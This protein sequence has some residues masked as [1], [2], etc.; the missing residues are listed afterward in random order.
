MKVD[1]HPY[2][3]HA[4]RFFL[5]FS[6]CLFVVGAAKGF[7]QDAD[8]FVSRLLQNETDESILAVEVQGDFI[9]NDVLNVYTNGQFIKSKVIEGSDIGDGK[10]VVVKNISVDV[11]R[12]G[13]NDI[14]VAI[15]RQG[16]EE[17]QTEPFRITIQTVPDRPILAVTKVEEDGG[18]AAEVTTP[19][20]VDDVVAV[21]LNGEEVVTVPVTDSLV[22]KGMVSV[23]LQEALF[24]EGDNRIEALIRRGDLEGGLSSRETV[25]IAS[26]EEGVAVQSTIP[27]C[28]AYTEQQYIQPEYRGK[29]DEFGTSVALFGSTVAIGNK[30]G[31]VEVFAKSM[32][33][34]EEVWKHVT[35]FEG[36]RY[37]FRHDN[38]KS[39]LLD[40][41]ERLLVGT[42]TADYQGGQSG[43]VEVFARSDDKWSGTGIIAP[44]SLG[45]RELFGTHIA[46][47]DT[48]MVV[49]ALRPD[50][51]GGIYVYE[52]DSRDS[53][54]GPPTIITPRSVTDAMRF[55]EQVAVGEGTIAV[56]SPGSFAIY[57]YSKDGG[58]WVEE[59]VTARH[60]STD[61]LFGSRL[62]LVN[63]MLIVGAPGEGEQGMV[64]IYERDRRD[65]WN[66]TQMLPAPKGARDFGAEMAYVDGALAVGAP[67]TNRTGAVFVFTHRG[68]VWRLQDTVMPDMLSL[69]DR[70]GSS[71]GMYGTTLVVGAPGD[72]A[73]DSSNVGTAYLFTASESVC[74]AAVVGGVVPEQETV[75]PEENVQNL[76]ERQEELEVLNEDV[77]AL[78]GAISQNIVAAM[79]EVVRHEDRIIIFDEALVSGS[80]Q[81]RAA[82][83]R[84]ITAPWI[85]PEVT[86]EQY[87]AKEAS[88][89]TEP[90]VRSRVEVVN[91]VVDDA[92]IVVP[93]T[94]VGLSLG[95]R[96][97]D[98]YRLQ[99]FLNQNG[100]RIAADGP[101]SP[102]EETNEFTESVE[103]ALKLFQF[104]NGLDQTGVLDGKTRDLV[105]TYVDGV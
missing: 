29:G 105:F 98:V 101:G 31:E 51:G 96:H 103:R 12:G 89:P 75:S 58:R 16:V 6:L 73:T 3:K 90:E 95:D 5:F 18:Y 11:L 100:Y 50:V 85:P 46:V 72:D 33:G 49:S 44:K 39:I 23:L 27:S 63:G 28:F 14:T 52:R 8:F 34:E 77:Q 70:F 37:T 10:T 17:R 57:L 42:N 38:P 79:Q 69:G 99:I 86:A 78:I 21:F 93:V 74:S 67:R 32:Q 1:E 7:A 81:R 84:G 26:E 56:S 35:D 94:S 24:I 53:S 55:G 60:G 65:A 41:S 80:A 82:T 13:V 40:G 88:I 54:W 19:F 97:E 92:G 4:I 30:E 43:I 104:I 47:N 59:R 9:H 36:G 66:L 45:A 76:L 15:E 64:Y 91:E 87:K 20:L 83:V 25:T 68:G 61:N 62:L 48:M 102:G 2:K 22:E 71:I